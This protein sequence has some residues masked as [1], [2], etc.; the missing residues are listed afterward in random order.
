[1][2]E[3]VVFE[4]MASTCCRCYQCTMRCLHTDY[5]VLPSG[6]STKQNAHKLVP[7]LDTQSLMNT[8]GFNEKKNLYEGGLEPRTSEMLDK[9]S[10]A[11]LSKRTRNMCEFMYLFTAAKNFGTNYIVLLI[12]IFILTVT[13]CGCTA[14][15]VSSYA[16]DP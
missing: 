2:L 13:L 1:M 14:C 5:Q 8:F 16:T 7:A 10:T 11:G 12:L 9:S 3:R 15:T 6:K 4:I